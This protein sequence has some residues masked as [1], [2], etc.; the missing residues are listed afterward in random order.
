MGQSPPGST[1]NAEGRGLPF[2][3][4]KADFGATTATVRKWTTAGSK[5]AKRGDILLS[6]RAPV[7]PT[8]FAPTDCVLGRGLAGLRSGPCVNQ[9]Y[10]FWYLRSIEDDVTSLGKGST[11]QAITGKQ[12]RG[13][14]VVVPPLDEQ[15]R[16]VDILEDRL[17]RLDAAGVSL[18]LARRRAESISAAS[19]S[20]LLSAADDAGGVQRIALGAAV[21]TVPAHWS[22]STVGAEA[23]LIEYGSGAKARPFESEGDV[24]VLRMGNVKRGRVVTSD[25]KYLAVGHPDVARLALRPGDVL[26]NRTNSAEHVGKSAVYIGE[27]APAVFA[28]YLI[29]VRFKPTVD[30]RWASIVINSPLGRAYVA[31][32]VSQQVGQANVNGTKLRSFPL[33]VPPREE[34]SALVARH[35]AVSDGATRL[36]RDVGT[37]LQRERVLR[38]SLLAA[39]FSGVL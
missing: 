17:S 1:Y 23:E 37:A 10:L 31:S 11:F 27:P 35:L 38:R 39:A 7:G 29:R 8:N 25:L 21:L 28:S 20:A 6:V 9:R 24:A 5:F 15:R 13:I 4:G 36:E 32:V 34:Q 30:P 16:I 2:F 18:G 33:P 19:S 22:M 14:S 3:Q 12:L 26:F